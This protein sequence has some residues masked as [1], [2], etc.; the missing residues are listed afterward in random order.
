MKLIR[1]QR[2]SNS[3]EVRKEACFKGNQIALLLMT[4]ETGIRKSSISQTN[5]P[6][7][8]AAHRCAFLVRNAAGS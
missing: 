8:D 7:M 2:G 1:A 5:F 4:A 3:E 6:K